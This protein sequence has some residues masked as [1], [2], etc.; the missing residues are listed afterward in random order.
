[1]KLCTFK[2]WSCQE[3]RFKRRLIYTKM[4]Y[5]T[6]TLGSMS[7]QMVYSILHFVWS[8]HLQSLK[9]LRPMVKEGYAF[10][11]KY[12]VLPRPWSQ[13]HTRY[14]PIPSTSCDLHVCTCKVWSCY[15]QQ[16]RRRCIYNNLQYLTFDLDLRFKV[17]WIVAQNLLHH[18]S[19]T[20]TKF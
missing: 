19:Y 15:V 4:H 12:A 9:L 2:V 3:Q 17:L 14:C 8:M 1:M 16:L 10:T 11:R 6:L 7:L 13:G 18:A 5:L 20:P